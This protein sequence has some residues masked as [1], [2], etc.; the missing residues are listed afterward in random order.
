MMRLTLIFLILQN[1]SGLKYGSANGTGPPPPTFIDGKSIVVMGMVDDMRK[2]PQ[3]ANTPPAIQSVMLSLEAMMGICNWFQP[4]NCKVKLQYGKHCKPEDVK[5]LKNKFPE[6][7][8]LYPDP[9][10]GLPERRTWK[11]AVLRNTLL[12]ETLVE[13]TDYVMVADTDGLVVWDNQ[14]FG[15]ITNAMS[16]TNDEKWDAVSFMSERYYDYWAARCTLRSHNCFAHKPLACDKKWF[17]C[18]QK[19]AASLPNTFSQVASAFNGLVVYK[20]SSFDGCNYDGHYH[21]LPNEDPKLIDE[22]ECE[23]VPMHACM[24]RGGSKVMLSS[25]RIKLQFPGWPGS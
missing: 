16:P 15:A 2:A 24:T 3:F 12:E 10:H 23:H 7:L 6:T 9:Q 4:G 5:A 19:A 1:A 17:P 8:E 18:I 14:T 21:R 13:N 11:Y 20:R 25:T 22:Q